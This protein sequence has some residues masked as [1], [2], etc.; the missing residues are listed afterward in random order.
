MVNNPSSRPTADDGPF[1]K[2]VTQ[3]RKILGVAD[4]DR[5]S[6]PGVNSKQRGI[7]QLQPSLIHRHVPA[8][9]MRFGV[10]PQVK[11]VK[12]RM[13]FVHNLSYGVFF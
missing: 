9:G 11:S 12:K 2:L 8:A 10:V 3:L 1:G 5:G 13:L 6:I 4:G 7:R